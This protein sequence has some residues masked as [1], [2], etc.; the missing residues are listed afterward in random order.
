MVNERTPP[1]ILRHV[2]AE[3]AAKLMDDV[4]AKRS[5]VTSGALMRLQAVIKKHD[6]AVA[7]V[8]AALEACKL[9]GEEPPPPTEPLLDERAVR[10][11]KRINGV[12]PADV[13]SYYLYC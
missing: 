10:D 6:S 8:A 4:K 1:G 13:V 3:F 9:S 12:F 2:L 7:E 5:F 11:A